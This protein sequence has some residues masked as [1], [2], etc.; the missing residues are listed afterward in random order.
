[1]SYED[2]NSDQAGL[3][4]S[5]GHSTN[6]FTLRLQPFIPMTVLNFLV[7]LLFCW[8]RLP[9][10]SLGA[11]LLGLAFFHIHAGHASNVFG[12]PPTVP[13]HGDPLRVLFASLAFLWSCLHHCGLLSYIRLCVRASSILIMTKLLFGTSVDPICRCPCIC[14]P[15]LRSPGCLSDCWLYNVSLP[16]HSALE[17]SITSFYL[18]FG[19]VSS[20]CL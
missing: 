14:L 5:W 17:S 12:Q 10:L 3:W 9:P 15:V 7:L 13:L 6:F 16:L 18:F 19:V 8:W 20:L 1:M 11:C 4:A 2:F